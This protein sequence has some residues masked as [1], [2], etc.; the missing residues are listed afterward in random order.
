M[1]DPRQRAAQFRE[2]GVAQ[3]EAGDLSGAE[4]SFAHSIKAA[5]RITQNG[6]GQ[7]CWSSRDGCLSEIAAWQARAGFFDMGLATASG[8]ARS[9][10]RDSAFSRIASAQLEQGHLTEAME[11]T[12]RIEDDYW[13]AQ[14][15][16]AISEAQIEAGRLDLALKFAGRIEPS[17]ERWDA[18][19]N[20]VETLAE[21]GDKDSVRQ[22]VTAIEA[23]YSE[24]EVHPDDLEEYL[25]N[26]CLRP[27]RIAQA[28]IK[29]GDFAEAL[30]TAESGSWSCE[31]AMAFLGIAFAVSH[32]DFLD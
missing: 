18:L 2:I 14:A 25:A 11:T 17:E 5:M 23:F 19:E 24:L 10:V 3:A 20:I 22:A 16:A 9:E 26:I 12:A 13:Q 29:A 30:R 15:L 6:L 31:R 8:I 27:A 1:Q 21:R 28:K 32:L 4:Q 7:S